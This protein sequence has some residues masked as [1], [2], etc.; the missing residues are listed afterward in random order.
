MSKGH[1]DGLTLKHRVGEKRLTEV[2]GHRAMNR[3]KW[4]EKRVATGRH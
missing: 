4:G 2:R 3:V 1:A